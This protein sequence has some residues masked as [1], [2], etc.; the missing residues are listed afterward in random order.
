MSDLRKDLLG[1]MARLRA[2]LDPKVVRQVDLAREGK[3]PYD[4]ENAGSAVR[5]FLDGR[6][7]NGKFALELAE[8]LKHGEA[9]PLH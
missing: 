5:Q 9:E 2:S 1:Q 3:V 4:R 6:A 7:D 8:K